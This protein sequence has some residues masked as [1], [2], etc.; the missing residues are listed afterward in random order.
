MIHLDIEREALLILQEECAEVSQAIS[1]IFRFGYDST[2]NDL[3]NR[4]MLEQELGDLFQLV[5]ILLERNV[6]DLDNLHIAMAKKKA[7]L[8]IWS[9]HLKEIL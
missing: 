4:Q 7:K 1:K 6:I 3:N 9:T 5:E 2:F 8:K